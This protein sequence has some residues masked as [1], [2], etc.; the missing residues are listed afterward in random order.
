MPIYEYDEGKRIRVA[1][2]VGGKLRQK[3]Y[4]PKTPTALEQDRMAAKK[5]ESE[6]KFEANMIASQKNRERSEK[7]RNSAYV[8][9]VGGIKMKFLVNTKHRHKRGDLSG[10]KRKIS[11]YT[12]AFV[13]SGSQDNKLFCRHFNIKT[14]GFN[15]AW[16]NAVNYLC[17]VKGISNNDQFLRKKPPVEQ[18][19]VIMEW[20]RAQGHNIPEHRLPDEILDVDHKKSILVDHALQANSH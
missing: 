10:K 13:V 19:Q 12:P 17:K 16:F 9:G 4:H 1:V 18:F 20:Q 3:Y 8:T 6:W 11:Y 15:M 7:R 5:L 14:Q 2:S